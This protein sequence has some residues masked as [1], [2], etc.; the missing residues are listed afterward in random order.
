MLYIWPLFAFF[1]AP[2]LLPAILQ[3]VLNFVQKPASAAR[4]P[5]SRKAA[6]VGTLSSL[7]SLVGYAVLAPLALVIVRYNTIVHPFT[8]ADNRHYMFYVFRYSIL[9]ASWVRYALVL[10][11]VSC[12]LLCWKTLGGFASSS[13]PATAAGTSIRPKQQQAQSRKKRAAAANDSSDKDNDEPSHVRNGRPSSS[14]SSPQP[15]SP[16]VAMSPIHDDLL[17]TKTAC[18]SPPTL[19]TALLWLLTTILSLVTAPLVEPRYFLLPWVFWRLLVPAWSLTPTT[20]PAVVRRCDLR[21][22]VET[23]W[24]TFV[25][26]ITMYIFVA[27]PF[28]WYAADGSL[29]DQGRTQRFMW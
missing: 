4:T 5:P 3:P 7:L 15:Q 18:P 25:N 29:A 26:I 19:S 12:G 2:L 13:S 22:W 11:Y 10:V 6:G 8:L 20:L 16:E 9:R 21:L 17:A 27:W 24:F 23:A 14:L 1:S 28:Y